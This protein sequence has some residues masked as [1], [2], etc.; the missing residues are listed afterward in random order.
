MLSSGAKEK[1]LEQSHTP[2]KTNTNR[3][4]SCWYQHPCVCLS[5]CV[6]RFSNV[7]IVSL[8]F[9]SVAVTCSSF[10]DLPTLAALRAN[11]GCKFWLACGSGRNWENSSSRSGWSWKSVATWS[12]TSLMVC[13]SRWKV[14]RISK[15]D[16]YVWGW[17]TNRIFRVVSCW[18]T[19]LKEYLN[20]F[21]VRSRMVE[22]W[23]FARGRR[24]IRQFYLVP[25][26]QKGIEATNQRFVSLKQLWHSSYHPRCIDTRGMS[27]YHCQNTWRAYVPA[28]NSFIT[29]KNWL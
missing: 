13:C 24:F 25:R 9:I 23:L 19:W 15:N 3:L 29:S 2:P 14:W 1:H 5:S 21:H 18:F 7:D 11:E 16:L 17:C 26:R 20:F 27:N 12:Y 6:F 22:F 8:A 4:A 10:P 28:L